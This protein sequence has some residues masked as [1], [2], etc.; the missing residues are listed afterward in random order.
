MQSSD[1]SINRKLNKIF[2]EF[3]IQR[4]HTIQVRTPKRIIIKSLE[5]VTAQLSP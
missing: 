3:E 5:G 2:C 4:D 1:I